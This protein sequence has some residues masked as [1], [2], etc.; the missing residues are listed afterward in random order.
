MTTLTAE[1][2]NLTPN[3]A[4]LNDGLLN[5]MAALHWLNDHGLRVRGISTSPMHGPVIVLDEVPKTDVLPGAIKSRMP[6][7]QCTFRVTYVATVLGCQ[8]EWRA[9]VD[10]KAIRD[11]NGEVAA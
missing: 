4:R 1:I 2:P 9:D 3:N 5:A 6:I 10:W 7:S 8:V 11:R